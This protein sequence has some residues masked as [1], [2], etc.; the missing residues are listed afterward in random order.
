MPSTRFAAGERVTVVGDVNEA[1][2][3]KM[4]AFGFTVGEPDPLPPGPPRTVSA[5]Q[6]STASADV[7]HY[8]SRPD[9]TPPTVAV[10]ASSPAAA[11]GY[12]LTAPYS[13]PG[14]HGPEIF[15]NSG[16][17]VWFDPLP[18]NVYATNLQVQ[19]LDGASVL[20]WWQGS[21]PAQGFGEGV[22]MIVNSAYQVLDQV[23]AGNGYSADLHDF[24]IGPNDTALLTIF[25]PLYCDLSAYGGPDTAV[26]DAVFE[27][28]DLKTGLVRREWHS[29]DHVALAN[30]YQTA[31][32]AT[33]RWPW[34]AFHI[35]SVQLLPSGN[36]L[37]SSRSTWAVYELSGA[38]GQVAWALGGRASS[39]KIGRGTGTAWQH[40]A[41]MLPNGDISIFDNGA[42]PAV[43]HRVAGDR[44]GRQRLGAHGH[45]GQPAHPQPPAA[46]RQP[47]R[48]PDPGQRRQ[49]RRLGRAALRLGVLGQ[50]PAALRRPHAARRAGLPGLPLPLGGHPGAPAR[51]R[52]AACVPRARSWSTRAG[53]GPPAW[54]AGASSPAR[55]R[56]RWRR[57][58]PRRARASRRASRSRARHRT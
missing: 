24:Q 6:A 47:G 12:V 53:T 5:V 54:P 42:A 32:T 56:R 40:D 36:F 55:R 45:A 19:Q 7:E 46:R 25:D 34:D 48:R 10:T 11:P 14:Q 21:I 8:V 27:Q 17:P 51:R 58:P 50:R 39:F 1:S 16:Q 57:S 22:E 38:T 3:S 41:T 2:G 30:S 28:V 52:R 18:T 35:N 29:I 49:L 26:T 37:V 9:L 4:F 13:G 33:T 44:R 43:E 31:T 15:D 20:S 23:S